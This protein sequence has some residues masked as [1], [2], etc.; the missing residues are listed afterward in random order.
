MVI[1]KVYLDNILCF[2]DFNADFTYPK[3]IVNSTIKNE[4]LEGVP[5][6]KV[7]KV[8]ILIGSNASG[9]TS[10]GKALLS[11]FL[12]LTRKEFDHMAFVC[13][14]KKE[15][16]FKIEF[17]LKEEDTYFYYFVDGTIKDSKNVFIKVAKEELR[18]ND[19]YKTVN[20]RVLA[21][22]QF[23]CYVP[24]LEVQIFKKMGW[25]FSFPLTDTNFQKAD[26]SFMKN[27][28]EDYLD[29]LNKVL[30]TLDSSIISVNKSN[31]IENCIIVESKYFV[32]P[33]ES[34]R[35][36]KDIQYLSSG[37]KYGLTIANLIFSIKHDL[38][39]F[40]YVDEQFSYINNEIEVAIL[41]TMIDLLHDCSQLFFTSHNTN[42]L[43]MRLPIHSFS[44]FEKEDNI[45]LLNASE[46]IIKNNISIKNQYE[47]NRFQCLP[48]TEKIYEI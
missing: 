9:K 26:L 18:A 23:I 4:F 44:F 5:N 10:F 42:I 1:A 11:I 19:S 46:R 8:N 48:S 37:T 47:N 34:G 13:D 12:L 7:K 32:I 21:K 40:Y 15:A 36:L 33:I 20:E 43:D 35:L 22:L 17:V 6:F 41:S 2:K 38:Y 16:R 31:E 39:G 30:K 27:N 29:I 14:K 24:L 25:A 45:K 28:E 3:K